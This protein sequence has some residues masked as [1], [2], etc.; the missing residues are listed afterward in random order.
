MDVKIGRYDSVRARVGGENRAIN[1]MALAMILAVGHLT[2]SFASGDAAHGATIYR[3]CM[4]CHSLDKNGIGPRHR[5]VFG[6]KAGSVPDY[7]YSAALKAADIVWNETTLDQWL[8]NPQM[9]VPGTKMMFSVSNAQDRADVIEFLK[10]KAGKE[11]LSV[12]GAK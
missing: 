12:T 5:G 11:P 9:L 1:V 7:D 6:R 4:I 10:E 3:E 2:P 8:T